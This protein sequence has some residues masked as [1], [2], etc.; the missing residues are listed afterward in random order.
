[1]SRGRFYI[2]TWG[3][4]MN[5][6]KSEGMAGVL[7][8]AG[9]LPAEDPAQADI[10]LF[11]T[12]MVREKPVD[13]LYSEAGKI[14]LLKE[15]NPR[16]L[17][18]VGGC[19]AQALKERLFR[20]SS[21][22]DFVFGSSNISELPDLIERARRARAL[23]RPGWVMAVD[24]IPDRLEDLPYLRTSR[25][26]A[27]VTITE[28]CSNF[29]SFC[30]VPYTTGLLR[31]RLPGEIIAEVSALAQQGYKEVQ[32]LGQNVDSYGKD[33][34]NPQITFANLLRALT[35]I[36]IA[37]VR[38][39]SSH[40]QDIT[41]DVIA[42]MGEENNICEHLHMAVQSGSNRVLDEM[43]RGYTRE[44]FL[45]LVRA[46]KER[47][48]GINITTDIIVGFPTE[49]EEDFEQTVDLVK[50]ARFGGA[51]IFKYSPR[52]GTIAFYKYKDTVPPEEKQRRLEILLELQKQITHE[53]N[54]KRIGQTVEVLVE[55]P[56]RH[57]G[58][59]L[60][61]TRDHKTV[62]FS[63][64]EDLTGELVWVRVTDASVA[65]LVGEVTL[66]PLPS[67]ERVGVRVEAH[68]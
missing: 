47:V 30:I 50:Q 61:K 3:C 58:L 9:Y 57:D 36:P 41:D 25:F 43:R 24:K 56:A 55:G 33:L 19:V 52:P 8:R 23:G 15:E 59:F 16:L 26:Q 64:P 48:P 4:Q 42:V 32:L 60:G 44:R 67:R 20:K 68:V 11:N 39:T 34:K 63:S 46:L 2:F 53:E 22:I 38:F 49:T 17:L 21:A 6:H 40:P 51:F 66:P 65:G 18:G 31:S 54:R 1:M 62:V 35:E 45:E 10:V 37:R 12:C 29:C 13:K 5:E 7:V 14:A 27:K 28:G